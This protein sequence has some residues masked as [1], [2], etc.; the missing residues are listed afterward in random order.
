MLSIGRKTSDTA[1][2]EEV[3]QNPGNY[4]Q[5]KEQV[6]AGFG[7]T[8]K[9]QNLA[10]QGLTVTRAEE[11]AGSDDIVHMISS[12]DTSDE[13]VEEVGVPKPKLELKSEAADVPED[14]VEDSDEDT[15]EEIDTEMLAS[16]VADICGEWDESDAAEDSGEPHNKLYEFIYCDIS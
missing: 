12:S 2:S 8:Q 1:T 15:D 6:W 10:D 5:R 14:V 4:I 9:L 7:L 3:L 13:E 11:T 16:K